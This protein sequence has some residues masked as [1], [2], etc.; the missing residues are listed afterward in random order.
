M[1]KIVSTR[2]PLLLVVICAALPG[3]G[4]EESG[5]PLVEVSGTVNYQ[6]KPLAGADVTMVGATGHLSTGATNSD[7][8]FKMTTAG[9]P[10]API[11]K[12]QVSISKVSAP[13]AKVDVASMKPEDMQKMQTAGGGKAKELISKSEIPE[14]YS[15]PGRSGLV[16]DIVTD[17]TKNVF[18]F[19]LVD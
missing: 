12:A 10:G 9:R 1:V 4:Q 19:N 7:G 18:T 14:K 8:K 5:P 13:A 11:G 2:W 17:A 3:C 15:Q 16:A 6:G